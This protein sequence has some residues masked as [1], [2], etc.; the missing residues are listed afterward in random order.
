MDLK[1]FEAVVAQYQQTE[2]KKRQRRDV[3]VTGQVVG[4][5]NEFH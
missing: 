3:V 4:R 2:A 1:K 5:T